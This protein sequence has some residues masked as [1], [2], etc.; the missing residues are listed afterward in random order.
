MAT[1]FV[2][3]GDICHSRDISSLET[4]E[5]GYLVC[6]NGVCGGIFPVLPEIYAN[7]PLTDHSGMLIIP[8]LT[9]LHTHAPQHPFRG[10][11][12]DLELL[13]WLNTHTFPEEARF[14]S[15][16][17]ARGAYS[18]FVDE[19]R[20]GPNTRA[21]VFATVHT[22]ATELLMELL[23]A[24]GLVAAVGR[25]NMDRNCPD[26][27]REPNADTAGTESACAAT[28]AWLDGCLGKFSNVTPIITP[29]FIPVC[30][31]EL[32]RGLSDIRCEYKLPV[33]SH[34]SESPGEVD[35]VKELCPDS[36]FYGA[37]YDR[38]GLFG[39]G[40]SP[41]IMAH[42]VWS[43]EEEIALMRKNG[44]FVAHCPQSNTNLSSGIAPVRRFIN[45]GLRV[46]LGSD[47]AGGCHSSILRAMS[48]A[49]QV[50]KLRW[51]LCDNND[52]PLTVPEAF[53]LG[54]AGGGSFFG[55]TCNFRDGC[56]FDALVIDDA[57]LRAGRPLSIEDRLAR[58]I[59]LSGDITI[60]EKYVRGIN[61]FL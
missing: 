55:N 52:A 46:G 29:R 40:D 56:E 4:V 28:R 57:G 53:Y 44:V 60:V 26:D 41:A 6:E 17:Y 11:G 51:R 50:S 35:W 12:M 33:Q 59:Y 39:G 5:N 58:T 20:R 14:A 36:A 15:L 38:F 19:I 48:D 9:D 24:S 3:K 8:G 1:S 34:L 7:L 10:L 37:A 25:V 49:I 30:S 54:T 18:A 16:D 45:S 22:P 13:D 21:A 31:D 23:E 2:L 27:L 43:G 42:C 61:I 47:M 32:M